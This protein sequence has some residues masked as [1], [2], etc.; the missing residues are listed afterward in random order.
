MASL[1]SSLH[2]KDGF[3]TTYTTQIS[4]TQLSALQNCS[5]HLYYTLPPLIFIDPYELV[6]HQHSYDFKH[7]G[8]SNLE[9]PVTAVN[10]EGS[11]LLLDVSFPDDA[12]VDVV[13]VRVPL[14][15]R[16]GE[17]A[18]STRSGHQTAEIPWPVGFLAC[19]SACEFLRLLVV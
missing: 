18:Q 5:L 19:P 2:P 9:L 14:H 16:Y 15:M 1:V 7:W 3:H 17:P 4:I 10:L 8:T 13:E 11:A 12:S 6:H